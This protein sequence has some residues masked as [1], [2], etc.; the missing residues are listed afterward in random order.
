MKSKSI[1]RPLVAF[2]AAFLAAGTMMGQTVTVW[3]TTPD[4][5]S[6]VARQPAQLHFATNKKDLPTIAVDDGKRFQSMDGF[7]FALTGGSAQLLMQMTPPARSA[8]LK[9]IFSTEGDGIGVSYLRVSVGSSDMNARV[10]SYDDLPA[11]ETDPTLAKFSL[12]PDRVAVIP[13]LKEILAIDPG[14]KILGSPWSAPAWMKSNDSS[15]GGYLKPEYYKTYAEYFVKYIEG[16]RAA[17]IAIDAITVQNEPLNPKNTPSMVMFAQ[18][19]D[20]FI[21][22]ALGPAFQTAGVKT[23]ILIYDHNPDVVSYALSILKDPVASEYVDGSAW[24]L[25]G[26]SITALTEVHDAFPNKNIYFTEQ[27]ITG[28]P[29]ATSIDISEPVS[30]VVIG[31]TRN[32]SKNVLLWNLAADPEDGPHTNNGGCTSCHGAITLDGDSATLNVAY[33]VIAQISKFVRPGSVRIWSNDLEQ[34][35]NVAFV[36]PDGKMVLVVSNTGNFPK[37]FNVSYHSKTMTSTLPEGDV[38]TYVW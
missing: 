27:S 16:M 35:A 17:G 29:H 26:G 19:E 31:A 36:T 38:A 9:Q 2:F 6:L 25:Y 12:A 14:I 15:K 3:L 18:Q 22:D 11:G 21:K 33:Y 32:W 30:E 13:V 28:P 20:N 10:Y 7:G 34:L 5:S 1:V 23:K 8:L 24:H 37:T 4:K